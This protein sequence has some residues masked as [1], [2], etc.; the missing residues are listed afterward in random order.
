MKLSKIQII[1][2]VILFYIQIN[3]TTQPFIPDLSAAEF[4]SRTIA[5]LHVML[6]ESPFDQ[7]EPTIESVL[8]D[9][10]ETDAAVNADST[11]NNGDQQDTSIEQNNSSESVATKNARLVLLTDPINCAPCRMLELNVISRIKSDEGKKL[12]WKVGNGE[13]TSLQILDRNKDYDKFMYYI[14]E[15]NKFT[16]NG[17]GIPVMF[18]VTDAGEIDKA[19]VKMG[20]MTMKEFGEYYNGLF[21]Q[22]IN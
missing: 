2:L 5:G 6:S 12:N 14:N 19:S 9:Q 16:K 20:S 18:K 8:N 15:L 13:D 10:T 7:S 4:E 11:D 3:K 21:D 22:N 1:V 17:V